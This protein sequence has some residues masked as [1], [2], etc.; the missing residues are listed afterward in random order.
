[1]AKVIMP[2]M[3]AEARGKI[4]GI[5]FQTHRGAAHVRAR[6]R[7]VNSAT[8]LQR[9]RRANLAN[10]AKKWKSFTQVYRDKWNTFAKNYTY[11]LTERN[12]REW[13][14]YEAFLTSNTHRLLFSA[15]S[16]NSPPTPKIYDIATDFRIWQDLA[17]IPWLEFEINFPRVPLFPFYVLT[18]LAEN[19][20]GDSFFDWTHAKYNSFSY[21]STAKLRTHIQLPNRSKFCKL[22][23]VIIDRDSATPVYDI[24][25]NSTFVRF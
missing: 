7:G 15:T 4:S 21:V 24:F 22:K 23:A 14:G 8:E 17:T 20:S 6:I 9:K 10:I 2:L 12:F 3:S 5:V 18:Y 13:T 19:E 25:S 16:I 11:H 1:M